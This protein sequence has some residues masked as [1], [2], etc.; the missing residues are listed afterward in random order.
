MR[1]FLGQENII[2]RKTSIAGKLL[3]F[4][5]TEAVKAAAAHTSK[6]IRA[7]QIQTVKTKRKRR[8]SYKSQ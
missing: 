2:W 3:L 7:M 5:H 4:P 6:R 8:S 1:L